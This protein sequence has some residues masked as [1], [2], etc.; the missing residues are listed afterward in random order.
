MLLLPAEARNPAPEEQQT[1]IHLA[2]APETSSDAEA[3]RQRV[4]NA[5]RADPYLYD[6]HV[7]VSV[8]EGRIVLRGFVFDDWDLR[9]ALRIARQSAGAMPVVDNLTIKE[10]GRS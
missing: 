6:R 1:G 10:G 9:N 7:T 3:I 4:A 8:E 2:S 5:L